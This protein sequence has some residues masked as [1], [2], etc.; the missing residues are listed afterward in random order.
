MTD[1]LGEI[2]GSGSMLLAVPI[3]VLVGLVSFLSP[4]VLPLIP[5]Y[6]SYATGLSGADLATGNPRR[7]RM[8]TGAVLFVLGFTA[9]FVSIG[10]AAGTFASFLRDWQQTYN[11]VL[12]IVTIVLGLAFVGLI[13]MLQRDVRFHRVPAVGLLAAPLLG[14]LFGLGWTPCIGPTLGTISTLAINEGTALRGGILLAC[15]SIGLGLP[16]IAAALWW[17]RASVTF[18][19]VRRHQMLITRIGG[20]MLIVIGLA[21]LTGWWQWAVDWLQLNIVERWAGVEI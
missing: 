9:V 17:S 13:P 6:L 21:L 16:F 4:C 11:V 10:V 18:S 2:T 20:V 8:V 1:W 7:W 12:G 19:W 3:A 5:G 15:Y 14:I